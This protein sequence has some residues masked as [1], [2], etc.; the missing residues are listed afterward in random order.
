MPQISR[1]CEGKLS[2]LSLLGWILKQC[3]LLKT[4]LYNICIIFVYINQ[5]KWFKEFFEN[6]S[7]ICEVIITLIVQVDQKWNVRR[8]IITDWPK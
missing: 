6:A 8:F 1:W 7:L 2:I 4:H 5:S 3:E